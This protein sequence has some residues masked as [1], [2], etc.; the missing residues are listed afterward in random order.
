M[1]VEQVHELLPCALRILISQLN[2]KLVF[3]VQP[4]G[5]C[6]SIHLDLGDT[7]DYN[8]E[9]KRIHKGLI[10]GPIRA[11]NSNFPESKACCPHRDN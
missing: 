11:G 7:Q 3:F 1:R 6:P 4:W 10:I 5:I 8:H 9:D 2:Q